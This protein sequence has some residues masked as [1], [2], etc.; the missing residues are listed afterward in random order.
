MGYHVYN[1]LKIKVDRSVAFVT[2][3]H[4][5]MN[6]LDLYLVMDT[7]R[8]GQ[9]VAGDDNVK[10]LVF[11]SA[12]PDFFIAHGDVETIIG[13]GDVAPPKSESVGFMHGL[14]DRFRIMPKISIAKIEG[15]ARGGGS[16]FA[17]AMDM[18]FGAI[19]K[20]VFGQP[21]VAMGIIP[22]AGGTQR[23]P[24]LLGRARALE[25]IT[26]C[27]DF[28]AELAER[29]GYINRALPPDE[30][31]PFVDALAY[32]IATFS[33]KAISAAKTAV[34]AM[35][36]PIEEGSIEEEYLCNQLMVSPNARRKMI[37]FME[38]GGQDR[39]NE[40]DFQSLIHKLTA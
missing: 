26:G 27:A 40:I 19:G 8:F 7:D 31:G 32:R 28:P 12:D 17:L 13:L 38:S 15:A 24:R 22:G 14:L 29:Y 16:E 10:V 34:N 30:L 5:P 11:D 33:A 35:N 9:E 37:R 4:Q 1:C 3:G 39:N 2:S 20:A 18:R 25:I 6:R 36:L 21:E 23:L